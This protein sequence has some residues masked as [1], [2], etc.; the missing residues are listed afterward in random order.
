MHVHTSSCT[1]NGAVYKKPIKQSCI[2]ELI[3]SLKLFETFLLPIDDEWTEGGLD[4]L[5]D[6]QTDKRTGEQTDTLFK[7]KINSTTIIISSTENI[8]LK[9]CEQL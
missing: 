7:N 1:Q 3:Y 9:G 8:L 2:W 6:G 4:R 5:I